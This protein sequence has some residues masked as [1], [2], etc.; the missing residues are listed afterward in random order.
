MN[1]K[2]YRRVVRVMAVIAVLT[3][4]VLLSLSILDGTTEIDLEAI[5]DLQETN[6]LV[7]ILGNLLGL[8]GPISIMGLWILMVYHWGTHRFKTQ[9][10]KKL[11]LTGLLL[12]N[13]VFAP[14]YYLVV[15]ELG[16]TLDDSEP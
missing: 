12:G 4:G 8:T 5:I 2:T 9:R 11:W 1:R 16:M 10:Q 15:F 14:I 7:G 13:S 3:L 6:L